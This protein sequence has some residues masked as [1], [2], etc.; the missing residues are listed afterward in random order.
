MSD[1]HAADADHVTV[2][3]R[4]RGA[5]RGALFSRIHQCT[6]LMFACALGY[7]SYCPAICNHEPSRSR[8]D[9]ARHLDRLRPAISP[10][11]VRL[12]APSRQPSL[13]SQESY[14]LSSRLQKMAQQFLR[15]AFGTRRPTPAFRFS[16]SSAHAFSLSR[17]APLRQLCFP[18]HVSSATSA[19]RSPVHYRV[20]DQLPQQ[21]SVREL[22]HRRK[23]RS[24]TQNPRLRSCPRPQRHPLHAHSRSR[25]P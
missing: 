10:K 13:L 11:S 9:P 6:Q 8:L 21:V 20:S 5:A 23:P 1:Q 14:L 17:S 7:Y 15:D 22:D 25:Q 2:E 19:T 3:G 16:C 4:D 24:P 12:P 18:S